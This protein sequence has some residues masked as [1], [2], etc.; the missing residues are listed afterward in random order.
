MESQFSRERSYPEFSPAELVEM[1]KGHFGTIPG[2]IQ[3]ESFVDGGELGERQCVFY[4]A[5]GG[6]AIAR[7]GV[8]YYLEPT[9][10]EDSSTFGVIVDGKDS[11]P[12]SQMYL[13]D[14]GEPYSLWVP[15]NAIFEESR[16]K[17]EALP[18]TDSW[19]LVNPEVPV[20]VHRSP[21]LS[22]V[23]TFRL[24]YDQPEL[25]NSSRGP[26]S[27]FR[28]LEYAAQMIAAS[29]IPDGFLP[30][31]NTVSVQSHGNESVDQTGLD[32]RFSMWN[33]RMKA[34][35]PAEVVANVQFIDRA[36]YTVGL[37]AQFKARLMPQNRFKRMMS[38]ITSSAQ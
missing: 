32:V 8:E 31:F 25:L 20:L 38:R 24:R 16:V 11:A 34:G 3:M 18:H 29:E 36:Y 28:K 19:N 35:N 5:L 17:K 23:G 33:T 4:Q 27:P 30:I 26:I 2:V 22:T 7:E 21:G 14:S 13:L 9:D 10:L 37:S 15:E 1:Q 6:M 12:V